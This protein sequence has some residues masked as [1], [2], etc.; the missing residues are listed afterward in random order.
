LELDLEKRSKSPFL[1]FWDY[2]MAYKSFKT[3]PSQ[4][5]RNLI[6]VL[7]EKNKTINAIRFISHDILDQAEESTR[8]YKAGCPL[9][10]MDGVFVTV[11]EEIGIKGFEM[12]LGTTFIN[13]GNPCR[14]DSTIITKLRAAGAIIVGSAIMNELG[15][16]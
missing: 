10:Q 14:E 13:D 3:T 15:W 2:H 7:D 5:A 11:K 16:E 8:R 4:V 9:G 12:K 1:S 6:K